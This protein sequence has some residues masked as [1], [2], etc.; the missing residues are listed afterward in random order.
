MTLKESVPIR[1][2][3]GRACQFAG[4]AL[5]LG[6]V[7]LVVVLAVPSLIGAKSS[8]IVLSGSMQPHLQPGDVVV[9]ND[10]SG[11]EIEEGEVITFRT[12]GEIGG[13]G[14]NR[15]THRVVEKQQT[16]DGV[17][18]RTKGDANDQADPGVIHQDAVVG[19]V[20]FHVSLVGRLF[21]AL[22]QP[23]AQLVVT[24]IPGILLVAN[25]FWTI[26]DELTAEG[27]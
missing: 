18:Y 27:N 16:S 4:P 15:V 7:G 1:T 2:W 24:V 26:T 20:W 21:L 6:V 3:L 11:S 25:G 22:Q 13:T 5:L 9:I 8:L 17:V 12:D 19:E 23:I 10:A 14:R